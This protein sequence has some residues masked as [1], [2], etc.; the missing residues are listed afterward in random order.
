MMWNSFLLTKFRSSDTKCLASNALSECERPAQLDILRGA[1]HVHI[2]FIRI[3]S[4]LMSANV[5][6]R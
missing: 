1:T 2:V 6:I 5:K 3:S 4:P